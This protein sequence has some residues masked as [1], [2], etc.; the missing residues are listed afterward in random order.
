MLF[1]VP[2]CGAIVRAGAFPDDAASAADTP[3]TGTGTMLTDVILPDVVASDVPV[4]AIDAAAPSCALPGVYSVATLGGTTFFLW[5]AGDGTIRGALTRGG[6]VTM[7]SE[8]GV[9]EISGATLAIVGETLSGGTGAGACSPADGG[10]YRMTFDGSCASLRLGL[11][12]DDCALRG[13]AFPTFVFT[14]QP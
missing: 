13:A 2:G 7:P 4:V 14:R 1:V 3:A 9:Y 10:A 6:L 5:F 11:V 8:L 12:R